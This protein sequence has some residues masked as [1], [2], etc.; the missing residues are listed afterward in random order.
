MFYVR[1]GLTIA[2][3]TYLGRWHSDLVFQYGE[4]AWEGRPMNEGS[5]GDP[6]WSI[7]WASTPGTLRPHGRRSAAGPSRERATL[8]CT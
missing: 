8:L 7:S 3:V 2:E 4:E 1:A 5:Q 6:K